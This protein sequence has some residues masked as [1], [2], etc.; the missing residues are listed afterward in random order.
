MRLGDGELYALVHGDGATKHHAVFGVLGGAVDKPIAIANA[1]SGNQ[2]ALGIQ[3][4]ENVFE[5]QTF[6][7]NAVF[8]WD[9]QVVNEDFVGLVVDHVA[10]GFDGDGLAHLFAQIDQEDRQAF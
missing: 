5:T 4:V 10:N 7:A 9:A 1:F 2:N 8:N 3:A 6:F